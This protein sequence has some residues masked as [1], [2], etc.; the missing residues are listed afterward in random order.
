MV[1]NL[2]IKK[3]AIIARMF[4]MHRVNECKSAGVEAMDVIIYLPEDRA[5]TPTK[6][7]IVSYGE[8]GGKTAAIMFTGVQ[9]NL[10]DKKLRRLCG[11]LILAKKSLVA[12]VRGLAQS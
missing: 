8:G 7:R 11:R 10:D 12:Y 4:D 6:R 9:I 3:P 5:Y 2:K 1:M